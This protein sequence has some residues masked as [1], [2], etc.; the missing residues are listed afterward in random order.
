MNN[1]NNLEQLDEFDIDQVTL[2]PRPQETEVIILNLP[3]S[4]IQSLRK[5]LRRRSI[6]SIEAL[7]RLYIGK[8][9]RQDLS[10]MFSEQTLAATE[11][12]LMRR[13]GPDANIAAILQEIR[14][15]MIE[16]AQASPKRES[17]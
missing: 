11:K 12:V 7:I 9:L 3:K 2:T 8:G 4:A 1:P 5:V 17:T 6:S 10:Q 16:D 13:L 14:S 15:T